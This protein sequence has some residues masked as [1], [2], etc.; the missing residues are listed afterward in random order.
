MS[1]AHRTGVQAPQKA[2]A[3]LD[4]LAVGLEYEHDIDFADV[5]TVVSTLIG[6]AIANLDNSALEK[7]WAAA[8]HNT[9]E[10]DE[11]VR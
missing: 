1:S 2:R 11:P 5:A 7:A 4:C 10:V 8:E 9:C 6:D 3:V